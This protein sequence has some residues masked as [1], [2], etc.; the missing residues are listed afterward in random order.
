MREND[1]VKF[2]RWNGS[3]P[4]VALAPFLWTLKQATVD[5]DLKA[6]LAGRISRVDQVLGTCD[7]AGRTEELN[8]RQCGPR[9][10]TNLPRRHVGK[11]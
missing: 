8:V 1:C 2:L 6:V 5:Q 3:V 11:T 7:R 4:P 10:L 9:E